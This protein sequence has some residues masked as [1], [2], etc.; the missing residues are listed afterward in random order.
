MMHLLPTSVL[1][2]SGR[3]HLR[4]GS[5]LLRRWQSRAS[6]S[7][8][9]QTPGRAGSAVVPTGGRASFSATRV[10]AGAAAAQGKPPGGRRGRWDGDRGRHHPSTAAQRCRC[11]RC[12]GRRAGRLALMEAPGEH[13]VRLVNVPRGLCVSARPLVLSGKRLGWAEGWCRPRGAHPASLARCAGPRCRGEQLGYYVATS[14]HARKPG[15]LRDH[16]PGAV[17]PGLPAAG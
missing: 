7:S 8:R 3:E 10:L 2:H 12:W 16:A 17:P 4:G 14:S 11:P 15:E 13:V 1:C 9:P 6:A 5:G